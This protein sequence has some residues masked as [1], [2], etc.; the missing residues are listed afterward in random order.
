MAEAK[1]AKKMEKEINERKQKAQERA[2][3]SKFKLVRPKTNHKPLLLEE[4]SDH[5]S[6][7]R[8]PKVEEQTSRYPDSLPS[9]SSS[10]Y[11]SASTSNNPVVKRIRWP[12][13]GGGALTV[14][15][16]YPLSPSEIQRKRD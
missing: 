7:F 12:G 14:V 5:K 8:F 1:L 2:Q 13:D 3:R 11:V 4:T 15:H 10:E 6:R 9:V 16:K